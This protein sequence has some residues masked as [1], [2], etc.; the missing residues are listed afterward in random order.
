TPKARLGESFASADVFI[1]SLQRG[2]AGYIVPSKLYGILAS[3]R[4]YIAAVE[5]TCEVAAITRSRDCGRLAEPGNARDLA[6][7]MLAFYR[8]RAMTARCG[9]NARTAGLTFDRRAQVAK[10]MDVFRAV[11]RPAARAGMPEAM[12]ALE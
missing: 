3:G 2:L 8:D 12:D 9:A 4:P 10:Y 5:D 1:V 11:R 7:Q 6:D